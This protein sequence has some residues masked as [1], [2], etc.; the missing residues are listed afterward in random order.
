[1]IFVTI[2]SM[3]PF[4]RLVRLMDGWSAD[5]PGHDVFS[6][7]GNGSYIPRHSRWVRILRPAE[8]IENVRTATLTIAHAG[9]GSIITAMETGRPIVILPRRCDQG[10]HT[11][12]HQLHTAAWLTGKQGIYVAMSDEDLAPTIEAALKETGTPLGRLDSSAPQEF[13]DRIRELVAS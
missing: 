11:T 8:F 2:G 10:E 4:D 12:D 3:F 9:M 5:H 13:L 7:I 6:Q 1:M